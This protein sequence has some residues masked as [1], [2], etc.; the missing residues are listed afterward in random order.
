LR[1]MRLYEAME[2]QQGIQELDKNTWQKLREKAQKKVLNEAPK[3][4]L[5]KYR[6]PEAKTTVRRYIQTVFHNPP[7]PSA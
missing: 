6:D 4:I 2:M 3:E 1:M 7:F 5:G